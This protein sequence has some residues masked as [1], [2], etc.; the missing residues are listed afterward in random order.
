MKIKD[1]FLRVIVHG[2]LG[3]LAGLIAG[4]ILGMLIA[5]LGNTFADI[6]EGVDDVYEIALFLGM[7]FGS[8]IGG[9]FGGTVGLRK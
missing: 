9:L 6:G 1:P 5:W 7:G 2:F 8:V 3:A 4:L